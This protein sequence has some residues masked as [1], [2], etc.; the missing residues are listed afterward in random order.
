MTIEVPAAPAA[1][2]ARPADPERLKHI[3]AGLR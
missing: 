2:A 3:L 1:P